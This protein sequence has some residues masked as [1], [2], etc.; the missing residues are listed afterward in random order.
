MTSAPW[1]VPFRDSQQ[2]RE[3]PRGR[4][5]ALL[6]PGRGGLNMT[7]DETLFWA[8]KADVRVLGFGDGEAVG[9]DGGG[10]VWLVPAFSCGAECSALGGA[11]PRRG[12][13]VGAEAERMKPLPSVLEF[14]GAVAAGEG[15]WP[16]H[17][18]GSMGLE[19]PGIG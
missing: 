6:S 13:G 15:P 18:P 1:A 9:G 3:T 10:G 12:G 7:S 17:R 4:L 2:W 16:P 8:P 5:A 11:F 19:L 14:C